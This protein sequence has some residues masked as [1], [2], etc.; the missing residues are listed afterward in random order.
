MTSK[1]SFEPTERV[2]MVSLIDHVQ[3]RHKTHPTN[4]KSHILVLAM[5]AA[6]KWNFSSSSTQNATIEISST[7][8][9]VRN[10]DVAKE[11]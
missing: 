8:R 11:E 10:L 3:V 9:D 4:V 5:A 7:D 1:K 6:K 2:T